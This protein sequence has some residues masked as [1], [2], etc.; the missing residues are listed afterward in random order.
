M[1]R[2]P[3]NWFKIKSH[4]L[5]NNSL[6][7]WFHAYGYSTILQPFPPKRTW[8]A[9]S[10]L[11]I[12]KRWEINALTSTF[13]SATNAS[14]SSHVWKIRLP[15]TVRRVKALKTGKKKN[16]HRSY[17]EYKHDLIKLCKLNEVRYTLCILKSWTNDL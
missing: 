16:K 5:L 15:C 13:P 10:N 11:D 14:V 7:D 4:R 3:F 1:I 2:N 8:N 9:S 6:S 12:G 17:K